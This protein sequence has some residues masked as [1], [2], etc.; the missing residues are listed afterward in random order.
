MTQPSHF[1]LLVVTTGGTPIVRLGVRR[2]VVGL[3]LLT[4]ALGLAGLGVAASDY[5]VLRAQRERFLAAEP[6]LAEH[7]ARIAA[8][9]ER[10]REMHAEVTGWRDARVRIWQ[11]FGPGSAPPESRQATGIGGVSVPVLGVPLAEITRDVPAAAGASAP[12]GA[13]MIV[14][15]ELERL[16]ALV[17]EEGEGLRSLGDFLGRATRVLAA[18]PS[19]WPLS[20]PI[21][22]TF[23]R[24]T[25]PWQGG[26]E[27]HSG[28]DIGAAVGTSVRAPAPGTVV[29][30]GRQPEY[31]IT[32]VIDH[33][34][35]VR[36]LFGHL[37]ALNVAQN[38][39]VRR[40]DVVALSGNTG[41]SSGPH[42]HYEIQVQG[43]PVNPVAFLWD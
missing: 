23:G 33:G 35:D 34:N 22:S 3:G 37:S 39:T 12:S 18:L 26:G 24:R 36:S 15:S 40:G 32:L 14:G 4:V 11:A 10:L 7:E 31:G 17:R 19:R 25:S 13:S 5:W 38:Q 20:G 28:I 2:W 9:Q 8:V 42:L 6:L 41:R 16:S 1:N 29:F 27:F 43:Q 30:A 21:N